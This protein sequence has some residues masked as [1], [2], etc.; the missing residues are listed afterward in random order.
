[1]FILAG[2]IS[3]CNTIQ[4][5]GKDIERGGEKVQSEAQKAK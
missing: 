2:F 1:M 4:G 3:G 5:A